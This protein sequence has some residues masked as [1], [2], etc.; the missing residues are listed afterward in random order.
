MADKNGDGAEGGICKARLLSDLSGQTPCD[1][2]ATSL[3]GRLCAFHSR[4]CQAMYL[5]YKKRNIE[6]DSLT[7]NPPSYLANTKTSLVVHEFKD[8]DKE[9]V[10]RELHAYIFRK[11][12]LLERVIKARKLHHSHFYAVDMDYGHEKY[13]TKLQNEKHVMTKA[14]ERVGKRGAE[15]MYK[16]KEWLGWVKHCQEEEETQRENESKKVKLESSLL[17][18]H[19]KE[20][21]RHQRAMK[22]KETKKREEKY[23]QKAYEQRLSE[24][25]DEEQE[26]WDPMHDVFGY[27][28]DNYV[29]LI[30]FFLML[31]DEDESEPIDNATKNDINNAAKEP[32]KVL[33]KSAKKRAKKANAEEKKLNNAPTDNADGNGS[34]SIEMETKAKMKARLQKSVEYERPTGLY[35]DDHGPAGRHAQT[36]PLREHE[37]DQV[38]E[39]IAEVKHFLFCRQL[40]SHASLLPFALRSNSIEEFL[41]NENVTQEHLRDLCLKLE[42]PKLQDVRDACADFVRQRD[43]VQDDDADEAKEEEDETPSKAKS[44]KSGK[45]MLK[46]RQGKSIP[47][48]YQTK[49]EK[50]AKKNREGRKK[51]F[52]EDDQ[53]AIVDFGKV[54][55]E[56]D[57]KHKRTHITI[58]G[59]NMYHYPSEQALNRG[60]WYHFSIIA[61]D[62]SLFDAIELCRNWNEFFELNILALYHFFPAPKWTRFAGDMLRMQLLQLG[63]IPYFVCDKADKVTHYFQT[64]SRGMARRAHEVTE[65]RNFVCGNM[66]RDDPVSRRFI[67]YLS[68][69]SWQI[70]AIV[71]DRTTGKILIKPPVEE[72]WL[73]RQK[74]GYGR[75]AKNEFE[76]MVEVGPE[77]FERMDSIRKWRFGFEEYYDMY[78]WDATPGRPYYVF[79]RKLEALLCRAMRVREVRDMFSQCKA[80]FKTICEDKETKRTRTIQPGEDIESKWDS[81]HRTAHAWHFVPDDSNPGQEKRVDGLEHDHK[82]TDADEIEDSILFPEEGTGEMGDN[83]FRENPSV[84]EMWERNYTLNLRRF[85]EDLDTD[86]E[87]SSEDD[88][89][90]DPNHSDSPSPLQSTNVDDGDE[91][92]TESDE[93]DEADEDSDDIAY[94]PQEDV[95]DAID[96]L[97]ER[98]KRT[99]MMNKSNPDYFLSVLR[100]PESAA[101]WIPRSVLSNSRDLMSTMRVAMKRNKEYDISSAG[102]EADFMRHIDREKSK[103]FKHAWHMGDLSHKGLKRHIEWHVMLS[104]MDDYIMKKITPG[105]FE[106]CKFMSMAADFTEDR[107]IVDD[108]FH[109]YAAIALFFDSDDLL[110]SKKKEFFRDSRARLLNQAERAKDM[111][112]LDRRSGRSVWTLPKDFF[113]EWDRLMRA[114]R[115]GP[116]QEVDDVYP[117]EWR[118][119][120]RSVVILLFKAGIIYSAYG[121]SVAGVVTAAPTPPTDHLDLFIDYRDQIP[122]ARH[123]AHF[124]DPAPFT[125]TFLV[126]KARKF[127]SSNPNA[128]FSVL[129]LWSAPHFYPLMIGL[130]NRSMVSFLDDRGR[131]WEWKFIP[132]DMPCSE[133]F[134]H[135]NLSARLEPYR[136]ALKED[137]VFVAKDLILVMGEDEMDLRRLS[138]GATWAVQTRPWRLEIDFWRS[139]VGVELGFLEGLD[140]RWLE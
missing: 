94:G 17:K 66:K 5:G 117:L 75:A 14:L 51:L 92:D 22:A 120:M 84:M 2:D 4:Q 79:Q 73:M 112:L 19:Q 36:H 59:R 139:F 106:L 62:S 71:R 96:A 119:A 57:Y 30:K 124:V 93:A 53:D 33:S 6:L 113:K 136:H 32:G 9:D 47:D 52:G 74:S 63:F 43:G 27:E 8:V 86:D 116:G 91:W 70:R 25:P 105:P 40:L 122:A 95:D 130:E 55:D 10:L 123:I 81:L 128:R 46:F 137:K 82:Y 80:I 101:S 78:I 129:R 111:N 90:D 20:L 15:V 65:M 37:A 61:K 26:E 68:M 131:L 89:E 127:A 114:R 7:E 135:K 69:E 54:T 83:L 138:A 67:Q 77:F 39:E 13:L 108:A 12:V 58:C 35:L 88:S 109:A 140:P 24:M 118:K 99:T 72:L 134:V 21:Q 107:R 126:D 64:G 102:I 41:T 125:P 85:A 50:A 98:F 48:K 29:D 60:G 97:C 23:L 3:D 18:R 28:R 56:K 133:L 1:K 16:Q 110:K 11:Y 38:L 76:N 115:R 104:F 121:D 49:R 87:I 44:G 100:A 34:N 132:K 45:Y 103:V 42:R 31:K